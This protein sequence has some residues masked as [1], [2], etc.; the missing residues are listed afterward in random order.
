MLEALDSRTWEKVFS[1]GSDPGPRS[2]DHPDSLRNPFTREDVSK[3][4]ALKEKRELDWIC[5]CRLND[6]RYA[7]VYGGNYVD[8][9]DWELKGYGWSYTSF[10]L[11]EI[12]TNLVG[13][14]WY[15]LVID[16]IRKFA[17]TNDV[18]SD[19]KVEIA[20]LVLEGSLEDQ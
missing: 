17:H 15:K 11:I 6:R 2:S 10:S 4:I 20:E 9:P 18:E 5:L 16:G 8:D 3:I 1:F 14:G 13:V 19:T 7:F 12:L